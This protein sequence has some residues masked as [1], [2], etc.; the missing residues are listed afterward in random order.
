[1]VPIDGASTFSTSVGA[2]SVTWRPLVNSLLVLGFCLSSLTANNVW[3]QQ[4][5]L[6]TVAL[7]ASKHL[8]K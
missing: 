5:Q 6:P 1:M 2:Y 8:M 3:H 4:T 7:T